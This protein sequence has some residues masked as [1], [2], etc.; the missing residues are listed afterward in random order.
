MLGITETS[1]WGETDRLIAQAWTINE[2]LRCSG[3]GQFV[4]ETHGH[5]GWFEADMSVC[6]GCRAIE[7]AQKDE[8][9]P[10][11]GTKFFAVSPFE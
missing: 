5:D 1:T 2:S 6:D 9:E 11:P 8:S 7:S 10:E 3:C 4:D